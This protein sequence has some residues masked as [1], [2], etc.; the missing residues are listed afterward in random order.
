MFQEV[1]KS[2]LDSAYD[3]QLF[4]PLQPEGQNLLKVDTERHY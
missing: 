3:N 4:G 2:R 1:I